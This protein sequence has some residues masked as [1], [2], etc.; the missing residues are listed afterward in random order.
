METLDYE[1]YRISTRVCRQKTSGYCV[2]WFTQQH[3]TRAVHY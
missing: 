1:T 3:D 2:V